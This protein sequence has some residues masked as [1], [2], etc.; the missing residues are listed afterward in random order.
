MVEVNAKGVTELVLAI[1]R[2]VLNDAGLRLPEYLLA[3]WAC[4]ELGRLVRTAAADRFSVQLAEWVRKW[5]ANGLG[6]GLLVELARRVLARLGLSAEEVGDGWE[7]QAGARPAVRNAAAADCD[8]R[9]L[10][11]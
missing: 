3:E 6:Q 4:R 7:R 5:T 10:S 2:P 8:C 9:R 1:C 11:G